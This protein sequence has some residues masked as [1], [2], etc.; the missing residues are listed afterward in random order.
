MSRRCKT[1]VKTPPAPWCREKLWGKE[2]SAAGSIRSALMSASLRIQFGASGGAGNERCG[3]TRDKPYW[4]LWRFVASD[5]LSPRILSVFSPVYKS[6][7][8]SAQE[9]AMKTEL[10]SPLCLGVLLL[11]STLLSCAA[12]PNVLGDSVGANNVV[13][14]FWRGLWHGFICLFTLIASLFSKSVTIYEVHNN[15]GWYNFGFVLGVAM[16][17]G[18]KG[19]RRR[20]RC[21]TGRRIQI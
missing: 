16:F 12:G 18:C 7:A 9:N 17:F 13:A 8:A 5:Q 20:A 6:Q 2:F 1:I 14:G 21:L 15:G 10:R 11:V 19:G 4:V 3:W